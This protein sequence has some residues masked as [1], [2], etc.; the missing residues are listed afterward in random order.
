LLDM[1]ELLR[2]DLEFEVVLSNETEPALGVVSTL[3][4]GFVGGEIFVRWN[5]SG[6]EGNIEGDIESDLL[7]GPSSP[8][9]ISSSSSP[10]FSFSSSSTGSGSLDDQLLV[11]ASTNEGADC[12]F[13]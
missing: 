12:M 6:S 3:A 2:L 9:S 5:G 7:L 1:R 13:P 4:L 8:S 10:S 11:E